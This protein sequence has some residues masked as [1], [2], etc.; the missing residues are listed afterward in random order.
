MHAS[1]EQ[2][3]LLSYA[4][5]YILAVPHRS[6]LLTFICLMPNNPPD[7]KTHSS[8]PMCYL[9]LSPSQHVFPHLARWRF[10]HFI[11]N[12]QF[13]NSPKPALPGS[14]PGLGLSNH[15][16]RDVQ[17]HQA[18]HSTLPPVVM[19]QGSPRWRCFSSTSRKACSRGMAILS[20][21]SLSVH[22]QQDQGQQD[23][24]HQGQQG[25]VGC[26]CAG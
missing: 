19:L 3:D 7:P 17:C 22:Q 2:C 23:K 14:H 8:K 6:D 25:R 1:Q 4:M 20:S 26:Q 18:A 13:K 5:A 24:G 9:P 16:L 10:M 21:Q 12:K 15:A 11:E